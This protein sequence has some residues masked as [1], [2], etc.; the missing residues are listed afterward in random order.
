VTTEQQI[1]VFFLD[2]DVD[3]LFAEISQEQKSQ[4][5]IRKL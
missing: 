1:K 5:N 2:A 3:D 4:P